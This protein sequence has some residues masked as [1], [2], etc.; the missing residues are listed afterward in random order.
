VSQGDRGV[1]ALL[2]ALNTKTK[3]VE[4]LGTAAVGSQG[5]VASLAADPT[6]RHMYYVPGAHG[7]RERDDS[8]VVQFE[9]QAEEGR[10]P[11]PV[12]REEVRGDAQGHLQHRGRSEGDKLYVTWNVSRV[13]DCCALTVIRIPAAERP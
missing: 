2:R 12:L 3:G 5:Y 6:G 13:W 10:V 9:G 11:Q 8:A 1:D 4:R 7:G